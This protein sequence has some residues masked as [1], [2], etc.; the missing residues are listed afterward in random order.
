MI[1]VAVDILDYTLK[2]NYINL[3]LI[4]NEKTRLLF[5]DSHEPG[6]GLML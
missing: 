3:N 4:K 2:N 5:S 6:P 1:L